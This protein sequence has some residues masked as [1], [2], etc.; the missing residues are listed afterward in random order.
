MSKIL[1]KLMNRAV[2][3]RDFLKG[4]VVA[5]A[6]VSALSLAGC[7]ANKVTES[8]DK[9]D[10]L[11]HSPI[12]N[13]EEGGTWVTAPCWHNCG[14]RCLNKALIVDG[15]VVRQKTDDTHE[16]SMDY[17]QQRACLRGRSQRQQVLGADRLKYPMKRK[18]WAPGGG[19]KSLRGQDEWERISWEEA[20]EIVAS[21][22]KRI[23]GKY[24]PTSIYAN[25]EG[26]TLLGAM[27]PYTTEWGT[28]SWGS[29][30]NSSVIGVGEGCKFSEIINDRFDM[31]N[32]EYIVLFGANPAWSA[33]GNA[34]QHYLAMKKAGA[35]FIVIDP[36]YT[37]TA[38]IL[39]AKWI[40]VRPGT[41]AA[42]LHALAYTMITEDSEKNPLIDWDFLK[43]CTVGFDAETMPSD[44]RTNENFKDYVLG[45]YDNTPKT[46][47]WAAQICGANVED[48][49]ELARVLGKD[50]KVSMLTGWSPARTYNSESLPQLFMTVAAMGGHYGKSGH[51]AGVSCWNYTANM[52]P[53]LIYPG[54]AGAPAGI[55]KHAPISIN[56]TE[57]WRAILNKEYT[58]TAALSGICGNPNWKAGIEGID[59]TKKVTKQ[60][61]NIQMIWH[62]QV[63]AL[64]TRSGM[65]EG[66][67]AH[68]EVEFVV[69]QSH[70]LT[71]NS[72]YADIV[73]PVTTTWERDPMFATRINREMII[74]FSK[75]IEPL[76]E[77]KDDSWI[78]SELA[79]K[80]DINPDDL[81]T[82]PQR[83]EFFNQLVTAQVIKEDG[84]GFED[85]IE[86]TE[87][88]IKEWGYEATPHAGRV[89][90][91][92][93]L[94][95][96]I[97]QVRRYEGDP[98]GFIA[99]D[100][101]RES[102]EENPLWSNSGKLEI[103]SQY[104]SD[105][106]SSQGYSDVPPIPKYVDAL[107][108]YKDTFSDFEKGDK[109]DYPYQVMNPHYQRRS[110]TIFDNNIWLR[111]ACPNPVFLAT[112]DAKDKGVVDGDTVLIS[113][114]HGQVLRQAC[115][116]NRM[117]PGVI[118]L[119]HGTWADI[120]E[121][122]GID[123][124]GSDNILC[125]GN[126]TG[127]GVSGFNTCICN[128]E[129]YEE[130]LPKDIEVPQRIIFAEEE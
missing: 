93:F 37:D 123:K 126:S 95:D 121:K 6:A 71:T 109:G 47:E 129:K 18:N 86:V 117:M 67:R 16:D 120:D 44:A 88:D 32:S 98:Y 17:P 46:P 125:G 119:P 97:Y 29:W 78:I 42:L 27:G 45:K 79:K 103:Y 43:R 116:T 28:S 130:A 12:E 54:S 58:P 57:L 50:N 91:K 118:G 102:P 3:R 8:D 70:F 36:I 1:D 19:D 75:V 11:E 106:I 68:R 92:K 23:Q 96:G 30:W 107:E 34:T 49:I 87:E 53:S 24:G 59:L 39:D 60:P 114:K 52:G 122:T 20:I 77:A 13:K 85:L 105:L 94:E 25:G 64:Q 101:F 61:I 63:A 80:F 4:S 115:V 62:A 2:T 56:N 99:Y 82:M 69:S 7:S 15:I 104:L 41:D 48:I 66:I 73:L 21:E 74:A 14:G 33:L 5:T 26:K 83:Q 76:F 51:T 90:L 31:R 38:S 100:K 110:H 81:Y 35:K 112:L 113:S 72:K 40:P 65:N 108:G 22:I 128:F 55:K 10:D 9:F 89:P 124:A 84:S 127:L 111:E